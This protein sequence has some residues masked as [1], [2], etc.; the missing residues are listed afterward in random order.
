ME[1]KPGLR[2]RV[3]PVAPGGREC[4]VV[5]RAQIDDGKPWWS[6]DVLEGGFNEDGTDSCIYQT[7]TIE[8]FLTEALADV[9]LTARPRSRLSP[10]A[11]LR[12]AA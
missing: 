7:K 8:R 1:V 9:K 4:I 2:F 10:L 11:A 12:L 6:C 5:V 3:P